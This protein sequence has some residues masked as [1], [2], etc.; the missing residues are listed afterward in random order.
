MNRPWPHGKGHIGAKL[1][2]DDRATELRSPGVG[3]HR[4]GVFETGTRGP[5]RCCPPRGQAGYATQ[6][7]RTEPTAQ[8]YERRAFT[9]VEKVASRDAHNVE[10]VRFDSA[11]RQITRRT[12]MDA[13]T[14]WMPA[15][16]VSWLLFV[17]VMW[18]WGRTLDEWGKTLD[19]SGETVMDHL[20][21]LR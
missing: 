19:E 3:R 18:E 6:D 9:G 4:G 8:R 7:R 2:D 15:A 11:P 16:I 1:K 21:R 10:I 17:L 14:S 12:D 5:E 13:P 20:P